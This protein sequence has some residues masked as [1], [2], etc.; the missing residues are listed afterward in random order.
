VSNVSGEEAIE[1][2]NRLGKRVGEEL[3]NSG[4]SVRKS[5]QEISPERIL[6]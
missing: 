6:L 3:K 1:C 4:V 2:A 5:G